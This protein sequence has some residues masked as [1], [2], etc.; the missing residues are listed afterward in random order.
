MILEGVVT[1]LDEDGAINISPMGPTVGDSMSRFLLRPF[2]TS[3][4]Y[5]NLKRTG[6]GVLHITDDVQLIAQA[7]IGDIVPLPDVIDAPQIQGKILVD[8]CRWYAFRVESLGEPQPRIDIECRTVA[9]GRNRDFFG[10]NRAK[11]AVLEAAILATRTGLLPI[12]EIRDEISRLATLV[13]KTGGPKE[14]A[15]FE[16]LKAHVERHASAPTEQPHA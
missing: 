7:A 6:Q 12:E 13:E 3:T 4:T 15:A 14:H 5:G 16:L 9:A 2:P 8:V 11:H 1:T 10:F